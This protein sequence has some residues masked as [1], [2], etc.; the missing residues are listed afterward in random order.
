MAGPGA[1][2]SSV[3]KLTGL[4]SLF[5][6]TSPPAFLVPAPYPPPKAVP[7]L[8]TLI[9]EVLPRGK[10]S[11]PTQCGYGFLDIRLKPKSRMGGLKNFLISGPAGKRIGLAGTMDSG[12][13]KKN[14]GSQF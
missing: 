12:V 11:P 8:H 6:G 13:R 4:G 14:G 3:S 1:N 9:P 5:P 7:T 2:S 10:R